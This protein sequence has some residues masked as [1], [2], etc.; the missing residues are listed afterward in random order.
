VVKTLMVV[1]FKKNEA[2]GERDPVAVAV[3]VAVLRYP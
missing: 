3:E 2:L 1:E